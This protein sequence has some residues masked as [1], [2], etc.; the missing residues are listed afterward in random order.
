M[1]EPGMEKSGA[2]QIGFGPMCSGNEKNIFIE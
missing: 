1:L 2:R